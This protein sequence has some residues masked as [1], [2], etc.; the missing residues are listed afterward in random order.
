MPRILAALL[1]P[2]LV[3][4]C[5]TGE[6]QPTAKPPGISPREHDVTF[7]SGPDTLHGTLALPPG[8][9][10]GLPAALIISGSGP[11]DRNGNA[12]A[13]PDAGTNRNFARVLADA[14]VASLRYDKLG[15]GDTGMAS[16][17]ED[18]PIGYDV[19]E[20]EV[21]DA[22]E[23]LAGRPEVDPSRLMVLG[24]SEGALFALRAHET[25]SGP[26]PQ[27]LILAAP[28]GERYLDVLDRQFTEQVRQSEAAG[29]MDFA[30]ATQTLSDIRYAISL[31]RDGGDLQRSDLP[32]G[33]SEILDPQTA[34]FLRTIDA[35][36]PVD[37]ARA[38]P[39]DTPVLVLR[40][41]ADSQV[42]RSSVDRLMTGLPQ[43]RRVRIDDADHV[44]RRYSDA[45]GAAVLDSERRFSPEVSPAVHG[46]LESA[47]V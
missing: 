2:V 39:R 18:A 29:S 16:H 8:A 13:R 25:V 9:G 17:G 28:P 20:Q 10:D 1:A 5:T 40:G 37:S 33:I 44:F 12:P 4:G 27:A 21:A 34:P 31:V 38:V 24:H 46:F 36:D 42:T 6:Q 11:T 41:S 43:A 32:Q 23:H 15:S 47:G 7:T 45:P 30:Q 3:A 35:A 19:F 26:G 14:G 22:Y